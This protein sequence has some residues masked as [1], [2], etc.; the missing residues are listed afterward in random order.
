MINCYKYVSLNRLPYMITKIQIFFPTIL[1]EK[2]PIHNQK[3]NTPVYEYLEL[4]YQ[5]APQ[6]QSNTETYISQK[7]FVCLFILF[8]C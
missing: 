8:E 1:L 7:D 6:P 3:N 5:I 2:L 4:T